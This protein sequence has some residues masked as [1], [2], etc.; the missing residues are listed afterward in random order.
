M[1]KNFVIIA[2]AFALLVTGAITWWN[3]EFPSASWRYKIT[4]EVE[5]PEG[6]K[7]G[8]A[9]REIH[10][11]SS[12]K[13]GDTGGGAAGVKGEAVV[14]DLGERGALFATIG[15]DFGYSVMF[16]AFPYSKGGLTKEGMEY[17]SS[18]KDAK[19]NL[20]EIEALPR[21]VK[22]RTLNDPLSVKLVDIHDLAKDFGEGVKIK[23]VTIETTTEPVTWGLVERFL[24]WL[25]EEKGGYL[26]G[27]KF[28]QEAPLGMHTGY[29]QTGAEH[30]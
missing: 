28:A 3:Y 20:L 7:T 30:D 24:P 26:G 13:I 12:I 2:A 25:T 19:A 23:E 17:Y 18:L 10:A 9:I 5:T 16:K 11:I 14:V 6:I 8:S 29:F 27:V 1:K 21:F 4:V 22:F 15:E